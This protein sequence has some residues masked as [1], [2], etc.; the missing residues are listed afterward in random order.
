MNIYNPL[1][2]Y[3]GDGFGFLSPFFDSLIFVDKIWY[4]SVHEYVTKTKKTLEEG[5]H[6]LLLQY[7]K[8]KSLIKKLKPKLYIGKKEINLE[9]ILCEVEEHLMD[10][11][12]RIT[13]FKKNTEEWI[14]MIEKACEME[15]MENPCEELIKEILLQNSMKKHKKYIENITERKLTKKELRVVTKLPFEYNINKMIF[16]LSK[17]KGVPKKYHC[18]KEKLKFRDRT[19]KRKPLSTKRFLEKIKQLSLEKQ[20]LTEVL[21]NPKKFSLYELKLHLLGRKAE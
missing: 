14:K 8:Y 13:D 6:H 12:M 16:W 9:K 1:P 15:C 10:E 5:Y 2:I 20:I 19:P 3:N 21:E 11:K 7:P 4:S 18:R 17:Y